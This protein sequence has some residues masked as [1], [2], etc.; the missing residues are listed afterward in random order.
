MAQE[1]EVGIMVRVMTIRDGTHGISLAMPN[2]LIGEWTD[3]GAVSL[4]VTEEMGVQI[5][6]RDGSQRY[7]LSMPG[8][9]LRVENVSETEATIVIAL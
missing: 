7:L 8:T 3:S 9:P 5:L 1:R 2:K 4:T 6:S